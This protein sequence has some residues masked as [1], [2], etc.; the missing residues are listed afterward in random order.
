MEAAMYYYN[1]DL[2]SGS[3][4]YFGIGLMKPRI[5]ATDVDKKVLWIFHPGNFHRL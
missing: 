5:L 3:G 4:G 2:A 1:G